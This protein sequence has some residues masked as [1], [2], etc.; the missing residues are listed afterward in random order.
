MFAFDFSFDSIR[1]Q[2]QKTIDDPRTFETIGSSLTSAASAA[3]AGGRNTDRSQ[4]AR[5]SP[6]SPAAE[7]ERN[8]ASGAGNASVTGGFNLPGD[9]MP[10]LAI[11]ALAFLVWKFA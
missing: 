4:M 9:A 1:E 3:F 5:R 7:A 11:G 10:L 6:Q 8:Y 2:I